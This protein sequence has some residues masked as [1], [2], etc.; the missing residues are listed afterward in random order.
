MATRVVA[1][2]TEWYPNGKGQ[3]IPA[4]FIEVAKKTAIGLKQRLAD[5]WR[6]SEVGFAMSRK[7]DSR[8]RSH[9]SPHERTELGR[10]LRSMSH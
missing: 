8:A 5:L 2:T 10:L 9:M 6:C 1:H 4:E 7:V 3:P